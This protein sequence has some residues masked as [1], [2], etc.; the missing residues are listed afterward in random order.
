MIIWK[1]SAAG[2]DDETI[3]Y[4]K[5]IL[6]A[7]HGVVFTRRGK[8]DPHVCMQIITE[9]DENW[10]VSDNSFSTYWLPQLM[11]VLQE[12]RDWMDKNCD[13]TDEGWTFRA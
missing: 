9:D 4:E 3:N 13:K 5:V 7:C 2:Y 12:A 6:G 11:T 8:D 1:K 10:F